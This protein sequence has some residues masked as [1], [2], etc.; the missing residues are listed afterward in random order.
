ML[1]HNLQDSASVSPSPRSPLEVPGKSSFYY[2]E[3]QHDM[4]CSTV[5][6]DPDTLCDVACR[7]ILPSLEVLILSHP[8]E[9]KTC[10]AH[11]L[12]C[13]CFARRKYLDVLRWLA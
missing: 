10:S 2:K 9:N 11:L 5:P 12:S 4:S 13:S 7:E 8:R 6:R 3:P 1:H